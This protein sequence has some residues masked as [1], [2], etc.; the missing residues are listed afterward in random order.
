MD[1]RGGAAVDYILSPEDQAAVKEK[2]LTYLSLGPQKLPSLPTKEEGF[3]LLDLFS[4]VPM[5]S[6]LAPSFSYEE[7]LEELA[8]DD[9]PREVSWSTGSPPGERL[10]DFK[11][12]LIGAG[13]SG[14]AAAVYLKRLGIPFELLERQDAIGGTWLLNS[15]PHVRVDSPF[16]AFQYKFVKG[17]KWTEYFPP[18][19]SIREY[20]DFVAAKY[21]VKEHTT[22][23]RELV[24]ARW[25]E[26]ASKWE[27]KIKNKVDG[28]EYEQV[29]NVVISASGLFSTPNLPDIPGIETFKGP[30]FHTSH[31]DHSVDMKNKRIALIGTGS[32]GTQIAPALAE[33]ASHLTVYQRTANWIVPFAFFKSPI[34]EHTRW[35]LSHMPYY[36]NWYCYSSFLKSLN[37][38]SLQKMDREWIENGGGV[39]KR[40]DDVRRELTEYVRE[41]L[42]DRP[43]LVEKM[44]PKHAPLVRRMAV[45][46][47]FYDTVKSPHVDLVRLIVPSDQE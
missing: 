41:C 10:K 18:G 23:N 35:M 5:S 42:K 25:N 19:A 17:Y 47:G 37:F 26:G 30:I 3:R 27:L 45:D 13:I 1:F 33:V 24:G 36:W 29:C 31:Y 12:V 4:D 32:T 40:N 34:S 16:S 28:T 22:F 8:F 11:V 14:I 21:G 43:D 20:L 38:F 46:N 44:L 15:Y 7:G 39:S 6:P 9:F 2:A